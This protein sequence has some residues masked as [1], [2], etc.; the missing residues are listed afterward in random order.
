VQFVS[1]PG[2]KMVVCCP[3]CKHAVLYENRE[4]VQFEVA[5]P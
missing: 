2:A 5:S 4:L 3:E 1:I